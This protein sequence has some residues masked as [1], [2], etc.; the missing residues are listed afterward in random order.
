MDK[1][2]V[3]A[4][5]GHRILGDKCCFSVLMTNKLHRVRWDNSIR[6]WDVDSGA[7]VGISKVSSPIYSVSFTGDGDRIVSACDDGTVGIWDA[8]LQT[9]TKEEE[10]VGHSDSVTAAAINGDGTRVAS[11]S[12]DGTVRLWNAQTGDEIGPPLEGHS[13]CVNCVSFSPD[14]RRVVSGSSDKTLMRLGHGD[15]HPNWGF[16]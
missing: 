8:H 13:D 1:R 12:H 7:C 6:V 11:A 15:S 10:V 16:I 5:E 9:E 2:S 3:I 14:G 4:L